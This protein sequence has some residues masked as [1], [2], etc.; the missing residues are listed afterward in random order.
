MDK[1]IPTIPSDMRISQLSQLIALGDSSVSQRQGTLILDPEQSLVG[2]IT[3]GDVVRALQKDPRGEMKVIEAGNTELVT[4]HA[5][6]LLHDALAKMLRHNIGRLPVV[7]RERPDH[8]IGYLGRSSILAGRLRHFQEEEVRERG[9]VLRS[10]A[11]R[12]GQH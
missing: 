1:Q 11:L 5:D 9:E 2:I 6:E 8:V 3:R 12:A 4:I 7:E 10:F